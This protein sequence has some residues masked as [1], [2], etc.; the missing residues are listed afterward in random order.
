MKCSQK[1]SSNGV[2]VENARDGA[3]EDWL[4]LLGIQVA[5]QGPL[6]SATPRNHRYAAML[7]LG[8]QTV[9]RSG[10]LQIGPLACNLPGSEQAGRGQVACSASLLQVQARHPAH[11]RQQHGAPPPQATAPAIAPITPPCTHLCHPTCSR[12]AAGGGLPSKC[13]FGGEARRHTGNAPTLQPNQA[14]QAS[15]QQNRAAQ[16]STN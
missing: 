11:V 13:M 6:Q 9:L 15:R 4:P 2:R 12:G 8:W 3:S 16:R 10:V 1:L 7:C 5:P 14:W